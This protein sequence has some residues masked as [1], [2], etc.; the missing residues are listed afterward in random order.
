M[1]ASSRSLG[2][3]FGIVLPAAWTAAAL[4]PLLWAWDR[5]PEPMA[6]HWSLSGGPDGALPRA[7]V[8]AIHGAMAGIPAVWAFA[9]TRRVPRR[10]GEIAPGLALAAFLGAF[11][12]AIA[13][14]LV[15]LNLD[16]PSWREARPLPIAWV[17]AD[18]ACACAAAFAVSR[19]AARLE[20]LPEP[21]LPGRATVGLGAT[22]RAVWT[23]AAGNPVLGATSFVLLCAGLAAPLLVPGPVP[24]VLIP[25]AL[26]LGAFAVVRVRVDAVGLTISYGPL[27]FPR[28]R[29]PLSRIREAR[30]IDVAPL[31]QG[32]WGYRGSLTLFRRASIIVRRGPGIRLD[33]GERGILVITVDDARTAAGLINDLVAR[34]P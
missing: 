13:L 24:L 32:G 14:Q 18:I 15:A 19:A 7:A 10:R 26:A 28:Q 4:G 11:A 16:A 5:L 21:P 29:V 30:A 25:A 9:L 34:A 3:V 2:D 12:V 23:G 31:R 27:W 1:R 22:E 8:L 20:T 17:V 33:C 6:S